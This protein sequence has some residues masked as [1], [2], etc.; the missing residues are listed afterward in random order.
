MQFKIKLSNYKLSNEKIFYIMKIVEVSFFKTI[1]IVDF[2]FLK[3]NQ[4]N[5]FYCALS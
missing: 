4:I 2:L 5:Q 1:I 3:C